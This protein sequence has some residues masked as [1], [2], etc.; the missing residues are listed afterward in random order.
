MTRTFG[1]AC[2]ALLVAPA[3]VVAGEEP[4]RLREAL[5][6]QEA[7]QE[8]VKK[9]EPAV[10]CI[11]VTRNDIYQRWFGDGFSLEHPGKLG[12]FDPASAILR[13]SA[14]DLIQLEEI[15][16]SLEKKYRRT[17]LT[18]FEIKRMFDLSDPANVPEAYGSGIVVNERDRLILTNYHVV[19]DATKIF[20]RLPGEKGSYADIHAADPRSDLAILRLI[21]A[22]PIQA[23]KLG[24]GG[25]VRKGQIVLSIANPFAAGY[26]DGSPSAS[27][28]IISN[29][30]RRD[31]GVSYWEQ[32]RAKWTVH[33]YGTLLQTD[34]RLNLGCSGGALIDL[35]GE[36][37]GV[38]TALAALSGSETA[39]GYAVPLDA[40]LRRIV[41]VLEAGEEVAYG[42]LG[43]GFS[44]DTRRGQDVR[45]SV[46]EGSAA[47]R[48]GLLNGDT[49]DSINGIP[50]REND[51]LFMVLGTLLAG[52]DVPIEVRG[53][54]RPLRATLDK[55]HVPGAFIVSKKPAAVRGLRVD[56]TS[57]LY[58][59]DRNPQG[60]AKGVYVRE[61]LP[62][63]P[64]D[65]ARLHDAV[66]T[67]VNNQ[68]VQT[69]ADF[70]KAVGKPGALELTVVDR[71]ENS[72]VRKV[73]LE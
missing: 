42:F 57:V 43:V 69:P 34:A 36:L 47:D 72:G 21:D 54:A 28:G 6:L 23:L 73:K 67:R 16:K 14:N 48:A 30:R 50:V 13:V 7:F 37:I 59:R 2:F 32:E 56:Y 26:K 46:I 41:E 71:H 8:A 40:N 3:F 68:E 1:F 5:A 22:V 11:L 44:R 4:A 18:Q 58:L 65:A 70:Y 33:H 12:S 49:I 20:V 27:W 25:K 15:K 31:P 45:V 52:S 10:A 64:A 51:D 29:I 17:N 39:G 61:V 62:G 9:A 60:M 35:K 19:R 24:D 63:S 55:L 66:I 53:K 38:T